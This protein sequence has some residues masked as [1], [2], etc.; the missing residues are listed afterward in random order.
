MH[1]DTQTFWN[2]ALWVYHTQKS[3]GC[4][5]VYLIL[6]KYLLWCQKYFWPLMP[7]LNFEKKGDFPGAVLGFPTSSLLY[8]QPWKQIMKARAAWWHSGWTRSVSLGA[9]EPLTSCPSLDHFLGHGANANHCIQ[10]H[11]TQDLLY[12]RFS[13]PLKMPISSA[14]RVSNTMSLWTG[15]SLAAPWQIINLF[16]S[17]VC[18]FNAFESLRF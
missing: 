11:T 6:F 13:H 9:P 1:A 7:T 18:S 14:H 5:C 12:W 8:L 2:S 16:T 10:E 15:C 17:S 3:L 4:V